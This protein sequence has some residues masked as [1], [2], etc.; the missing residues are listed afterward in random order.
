MHMSKA[1]RTTQYIIETVAPIFNRN[2]YNGTSM[3]AITK[4]TGLTKGAV[5]GN[6]ESKEEL[7]LKSFNHNVRTV[8]GR[9]TE[10]MD[11]EDSYPEKLRALTRFYRN[12]PALT[13]DLGGCPLLNVGVDSNYQNELLMNR[14]KEVNL[15][16][17]RNL[18]H[19][20]KMGM[21]KKQ[22]KPTLDSLKIAGRIIAM[23]E[24]SVYMTFT[25]NDNSYMLDMMDHVDD[26][27]KTEMIS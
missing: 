12:Y 21:N 20:I 5:Y 15:K 14:V 13:S 19:L 3:S 17:R 11:A 9:L 27:I 22:F 25:L 7:A 26:M 2:G 8:F 24:G 6:F 18:G 4:A 16:L 1:D 23:I 10:V